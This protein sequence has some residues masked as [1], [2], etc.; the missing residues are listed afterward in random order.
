MFNFLNPIFLF[1]A[2]VAV[3]FPLLIHL[4]NRQKVKKVYFSSLLFL[5]SL[6]KTRMRRVKIKEYL[7]L[8]IR[9]LIILLVVAAFAR[10]AIRGGF[11]S[12][13][14]A[15]AKTSTVIL[16]DDSYSMRYETKEGSL[17]DLSKRKAKEII[18]QL[19]EGDEASLILFSSKPELTRLKPTYDFK[20]LLNQLDEVQP[21]YQITD[22]GQALKSAFEILKDSKNLNQETYLISDM[23]KSGWSFGDGSFSSQENGQVKLYLLDVWPNEKQNLCIDKI[24]FGNQ[25]IEKGRPFQIKAQVTNFTSQP[26]K[27]FLVGLYLDGRRVSQTDIDI[28]RGGKA[29]VEFTHA[30]DAAGTHT[31]FFEI[32]DDDLMIDNRRYFAFKIPE[33]IEVLLVGEHPRDTY[34]LKLA[35]NPQQ[36]SDVHMVVSEADGKSLAGVDFDKY[37]AIIFSNLSK[38][39]DVGVTNL[40]RFVQRG[41]GVLFILGN[42]V[43]PQFYRQEIIKR[44]FDLDLRLPVT[45]TKNVGGFFTLEKIDWDHPIFQ[46]YQNVEENK[47]PQMEFFSLFE[48]PE[49][50]KVK[51]VSRFNLGRPAL[52][53]RK[54][55]SGKVLLFAASLDEK[56]SDLVVHPFFVPFVN[57]TVEYL[58]SD[59]TKLFEDILVGSR[60]ER[61]LAPEMSR[62]EIKLVDPENLESSLAPSIQK[63]KLVLNIQNTEK[64][65]IYKIKAE[66]K[67]VDQF[68]VNIDP[69]DSDPQKI[70]K[71]EI[72]K[73]LKWLSLFYIKPDDDIEKAI[74]QF[75]YGKEL[76]KPFLWIVVGL[77]GLEMY[78]ARSRKKDIV[79]EE[80]PAPVSST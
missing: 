30:V 33:K 67:V 58:A 24:D 80:T 69:K 15:H 62:E 1:A 20:N 47:L 14:G 39:S 38:L 41:G 26:V 16:L 2:G 43:D 54:L 52:M 29:T 46:V 57:R 36:E 48:L 23:E 6:E 21:S 11:A 70:E 7:L 18:S 10:P 25:L 3:L 77:L 60:V 45:A 76:W 73:K 12:R 37:Q 65:G 51:V 50:E 13:V 79:S 35:L 72:E 27:N 71:S 78:L 53:E 9:S 56:E 63:D 5:R 19:K 8:L 31:G 4:F 32:T 59:L 64:P 17:F 49:S 55:G 22:V 75:R 66:E 28:E 74:L 40:E 44:F 34:H 68:A 61:E 42:N